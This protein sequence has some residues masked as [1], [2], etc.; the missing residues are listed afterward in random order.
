MLRSIDDFDLIGI[1]ACHTHQYAWRV[2]IVN[3]NVDNVNV[4]FIYNCNIDIYMDNVLLM[5]M[6]LKRVNV[7]ID[8]DAHQVLIDFQKINNYASKDKALAELLREFKKCR[9]ARS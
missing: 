5:P 7:V 9:D 2:Y 8:E 6:E 3:Y 1:H 4:N